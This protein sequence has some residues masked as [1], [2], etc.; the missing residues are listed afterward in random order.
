MNLM[1][2]IK[3][4]VIRNTNQKCIK[5][6]IC[7]NTITKHTKN[8]MKLFLLVYNFNEICLFTF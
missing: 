6:N 3:I 8:D 4:I 5:K 1:K 7:T 2:K